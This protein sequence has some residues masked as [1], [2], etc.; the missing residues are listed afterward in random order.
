MS[1]NDVKSTIASIRNVL[2]LIRKEGER[3]Q[4]RA[5]ELDRA[6]GNLEQSNGISVVVTSEDIL[7]EAI[8]VSRSDGPEISV[9]RI[10]EALSD[11]GKVW[12]FS[13]PKAVISTVLHRSG[14]FVRV[15]RGVFACCG[16]SVNL[17]GDVPGPGILALEGLS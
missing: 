15:R 1:N 7:A 17:R 6:L 3:L 5:F 10:H 14:K 11:R 12:S 8:E 9:D 2:Q 13:N 4:N 16:Y